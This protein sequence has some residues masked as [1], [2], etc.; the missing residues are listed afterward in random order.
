MKHE[1][2]FAKQTTESELSVCISL[3]FT[4]A[5]SAFYFK[6]VTKIAESSLVEIKHSILP[7]DFEQL[8]FQAKHHQ[9]KK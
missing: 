3:N 1:H 6:Y 7:A 8:A 5:G 9:T 4:S 2:F